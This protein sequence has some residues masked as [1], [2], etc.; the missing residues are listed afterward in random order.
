MKRDLK[1]FVLISCNES[2]SEIKESCW[3]LEDASERRDRIDG[4]GSA[5]VEVEDEDEEEESEFEI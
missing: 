4:I 5:F 2:F 3:V 1:A